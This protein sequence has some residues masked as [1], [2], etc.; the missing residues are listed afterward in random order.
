MMDNRGYR[1]ALRNVYLLLFHGNSG[2]ANAPQC[3]VI[4]KLPVLLIMYRQHSVVGVY[5]RRLGSHPGKGRRFSLLRNVQTRSGRLKLTAHLHLVPWLRMSGTIHFLPLYVFVVW[6]GT[7]LPFS[8]LEWNYD[9][10]HVPVWFSLFKNMKILPL[11]YSLLNKTCKKFRISPAHGRTAL[12]PASLWLPI[13]DFRVDCIEC[14][15]W[16]FCIDWIQLNLDLTAV[17]R[18]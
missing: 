12:V 9:C 10:L 4:R 14:M 1:H 16:S 15:S 8:L 5:W 7:A 6:T 17:S 13:R 18:G 2:Y 3:Y 11:F